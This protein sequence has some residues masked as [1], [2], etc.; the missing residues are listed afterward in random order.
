MGASSVDGLVRVRAYQNNHS[1]VPAHL[2][3][4]VMI[5]VRATTLGRSVR[6]LE[7]KI[8]RVF[9][10]DTK[11]PSGDRRSTCRASV[12]ADFSASGFIVGVLCAT[13]TT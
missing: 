2:P 7:H 12:V 1:R 10:R 6:V 4:G 3:S 13:R 5:G 11:L 9:P 8:W